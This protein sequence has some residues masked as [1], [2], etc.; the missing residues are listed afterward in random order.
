MQCY[1]LRRQPTLGG[2]VR[3][4][5]FDDQPCLREAEPTESC[6]GWKVGSARPP[7]ATQVGELVTIFHFQNSDF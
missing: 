7:S 4:A 5:G 6:A 3:D 2:N 1:L